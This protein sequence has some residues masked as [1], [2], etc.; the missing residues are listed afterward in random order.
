MKIATTT[1]SEMKRPGH[2]LDASYHASLGVKALQ[3]LEKWGGIKKHPNDSKPVLRESS[4][5]Y[6]ENRVELLSGICETGGIYIPSRF[7]RIFVDDEKHG[8]PYITGG[9]ILE[10]D[11]LRGAKLLSNRFTASMDDLALRKKMILVTCSGTIGNATYVNENFKNAVGSPDL[12]RIIADPKSIPPGYLYA[13]I[14]SK[15]G[16]S[17]IEQKTY[18]AVVKHI[19]AHHVYDLLVP[20][21][22]STT[23]KEIHDLIEE[24]SQHRVAANQELER[25]QKRFLNDVLGLEKND[26]TWN[27][28][29]EHAFAT[30]TAVLSM[31][32]HRLDAFHYV[33][34]VQEAEDLLKDTVSLGELISPYQPP[35]F[36]RPYTDETGIPFLSGMDLY[37]AYPKPRLYISRKMP[38]LDRYLVEA[39]TILVQNVGQRYGL[40]GRPTILQKHLDGVSVTQHLMRVYP[41]DS[42]DRGFVYIWLSTEVG[43]RLLLKQS[44][45]TSMGV[46]FEHS[47]REMPAPKCSAALRHSFESE[48]QAICDYRDKAN[49]LEDEAQSILL[50]AL[51]WDETSM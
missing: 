22:S 14:N 43:R 32:H 29:N 13:F 40:F 41:K 7:K 37:N 9:S 26:L 50:N 47:F 36:K 17:L 23:E 35:V 31:K 3:Y 6:D 5:I 16:Y 44:F 10:A 34:Y 1:V 12:L 15:L 20:R 21:L 11:P 38:N 24:S 18:G 27:H 25:V 30:G 51:G 46:L 49:E 4:V 39:G 8:T 42:R 45:G 2:R 48:V 19:E 33:G 28:S